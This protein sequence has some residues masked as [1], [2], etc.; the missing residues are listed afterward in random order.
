MAKP[1]VLVLTP[2]FPPEKGGI[3]ILVHRVISSWTRL[4]P[5]VVTLATLDADEF[6][7]D[8][9]FSVHRVGGER[10]GHRARLAALNAVA[11]LV[12][13]GRRPD[14]VLSGHIVMSP[15]AWLISRTLRVPFL[16]YLYGQEVAVRPGLASFAVR[17][18]ACSIAIS[19]HT[20]A[21]AAYCGADPGRVRRIYPGV[22]RITEAAAV[23][24]RPDVVVVARLDE[25]YKGH[26]VLIRALPLIRARVPH[27]RLVVIGDG[28]LR[29]AYES[30]AASFGVADAVAFL[31][32]VDDAERDRLLREASVFAMPSRQLGAGEGEGFGIVFLE[33]GTHH[34]PVVAGAVAGTLDAVVDGETGLL[35]DPQD[36]LAVADAITR[37][38]LEPGL[39]K[40]LGDNGAERAEGFA[41]QRVSHAVEDVVLELV[42]AR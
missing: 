8:L 16:Q 38:L 41:W 17:N 33:A 31:G 29:P 6:D 37:L 40:R 25:R 5:R 30:L 11:S 9:Q 3:Q 18:A 27:A 15:A 42:E 1:S 36:H 20:E 24:R 14:V 13:L 2:D 32:V 26:D 34:L 10:V 22:D 35:V 7:R 21:L 12:G 28:G 39:A 19:R 4:E 23:R